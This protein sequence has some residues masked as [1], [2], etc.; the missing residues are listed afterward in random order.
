M[1]ARYTS[2]FYSEKGRKYYLVIDD[3]DFSGATYDVDVTSGQ[4]EWQADVENGL[5]RYAPII[6]SNFKFSIII[7]TEQKKQLLTDFL[8]APEGRFTDAMCSYS[9]SKSFICQ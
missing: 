5:E 2:T 9:I 7:D 8:T 3:T 6:G 4:I 1:A